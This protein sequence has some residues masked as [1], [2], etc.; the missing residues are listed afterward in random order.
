MNN[1]YV[2]GVRFAAITSGNKTRYYH[3]DQVDSVSLV[4]DE[5]GTAVHRF[6]YLLTQQDVAN[7]NAARRAKKALTIWGELA[8]AE[9]YQG[10]N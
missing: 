8:K 2:N 6:E 9:E 4:T 3:T 1:I 10:R 5:D 7:V